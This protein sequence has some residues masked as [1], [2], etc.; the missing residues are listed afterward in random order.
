MRKQT[1]FI[2]LGRLSQGNRAYAD[3]MHLWRRSRPGLLTN[4][5]FRVERTFAMRWKPRRH[6]R[7]RRGSACGAPGAHALPEFTSVAP[8]MIFRSVCALQRQSLS[9]GGAQ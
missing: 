4:P 8:R 5:D 3:A 1:R 9:C 6:L 2:V 7:Y